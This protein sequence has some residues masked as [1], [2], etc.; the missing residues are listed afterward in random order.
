MRRALLTLFFAAIPATAHAAAPSCK[1]PVLF[2]EEIAIGN[3]KLVD[4]P[5]GT[6][7]TVR[8]SRAEAWATFLPE[9]WRVPP[10]YTGDPLPIGGHVAQLTGEAHG[11]RYFYV[12]VDPDGHRGTTPAPGNV[13]F[14]LFGTMPEG[15]HVLAAELL[16]D[17]KHVRVMRGQPEGKKWLVENEV[18]PG[19]G[20]EL[21]GVR[22][23]LVR[24]LPDL[25]WGWME[26]A[27][28][29]PARFARGK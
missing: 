4:A 16:D 23:R 26:L 2:S 14:P 29:T 20:F 8:P 12:C 9:L 15:D 17:G 6:L 10:S 22:V 25:G 5:D 11:P 21:E 19:D 1:T 24:V 7:I 18:A 13:L 28:V 3:G 27:R